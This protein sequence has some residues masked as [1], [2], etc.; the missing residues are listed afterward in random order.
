MD[1]EAHL[2]LATAIERALAGRPLLPPQV[3][4]CGACGALLVRYHYRPRRG[5]LR[6]GRGP[7]R[8][9]NS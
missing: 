4:H 2:D 1:I 8:P 7:R 3:V 9:R 6:A 5:A